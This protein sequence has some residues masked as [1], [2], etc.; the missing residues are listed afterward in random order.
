M[1]VLNFFLK[2]NNFKIHN[3]IKLYG[4][5]SAWL[6]LEKIL[7]LI[8]GILIGVW[9][10]KYLG[11]EKFGEFSF[12][13]VYVGLFTIIIGLGLD[14]IVVEELLNNK[15]KKEEII[16]TTFVLKLLSAL[17]IFVIILA[18]LIFLNF[19]Q[20][21]S[22]LI[23]IFSLSLFI[24]SLDVIKFFFQAMVLSKYEAIA[25]IIA[26]IFSSFFKVYLILEGFGLIEFAYVYVFDIFLLALG[27]I[28][29]YNFKSGYNYHF[30]KFKKSIAIN[31]LTRSW[32]LI[33]SGLAISLFMKVDQLMIDHFLDQTSLGYYAAAVK[34][35][36]AWYFVPII[37]ANSFFP[38]LINSKKVSEK[39]YNI[40]LS[41][42]FKAMF[43]L[44]IIIAIIV[45]F[46]KDLII[47]KL[48]GESFLPATK[49]LMIHIWS[50]VFVFMGMISSN[51]MIIENLEKLYFKRTIY[52]LIS[53]IILNLL[54]IPIF[55]IIGAAI[56][57]IISQS[58]VYY[59]SDLLNKQTI[60]LFVLKNKS[61]FSIK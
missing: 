23:F 9:V 38:S 11:P 36:E 47:I 6:L 25:S 1:K 54:L 32:P 14:N 41:Y 42:L 20:I 15:N 52:G 48:Y 22:K 34:L 5:N 24:Q 61:F 3:G 13:M 37:I 12:A 31:L 29:F 7:R 19:S 35:S 27:L 21:R 49:V 39:L 59:F 60:K 33:I 28:I 2:N 55:G 30:L 10:A 58:I 57:T 45:T 4:F 53:N 16:A 43:W 51:W 50:S 44:S 40:R 26:L 46:F 17:I 8:L 56:S 18:S